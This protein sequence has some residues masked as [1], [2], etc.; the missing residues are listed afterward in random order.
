MTTT[1]SNEPASCLERHK[2]RELLPSVGTA[3]NFVFARLPANL[4]NSV[5]DTPLKPFEST[6]VFSMTL[7]FE[8]PN[9]F[10]ADIIVSS[11][12]IWGSH[13]FNYEGFVTWCTLVRMYTNISYNLLPQSS[14]RKMEAASSS[15]KFV[16]AYKSARHQFIEKV[17]L[18]RM[19]LFASYP[20]DA[21]SRS[22]A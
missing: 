10:I 19:Y 13:D 22:Y 5:D 9:L 2:Q 8:S 7:I 3:R 16:T 21:C 1:D 15:R 11:L 18:I 4:Q 17:I 6:T 20:L 12:D 14:L